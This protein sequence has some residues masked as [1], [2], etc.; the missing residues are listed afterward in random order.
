MDT[1][2]TH[3]ASNES[4]AVR[5]AEEEVNAIE[6][7][8]RS[9]LAIMLTQITG[10]DR[11][12]QISAA[13]M[14]GG[15]K[16]LPGHEASNVV[17]TEIVSEGFPENGD[18]PVRENTSIQEIGSSYVPV[19]TG[20]PAPLEPPIIPVEDMTSDDLARAISRILRKME[21]DP[22]INKTDERH[23]TKKLYGASACASGSKHVSIVYVAYQGSSK[24]ELD[25][26]RKM[27]E[28]LRKGELVRHY[29]IQDEMKGKT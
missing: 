27:L 3:R 20:A 5:M 13:M 15:Q 11:I 8:V 4:F 25:V 17:K 14:P 26:A 21:A 18:F 16:A 12:G 22:A 6:N 10:D 29:T 9:G 19:P 1:V 7:D 24:V 23:G 2:A 28:R